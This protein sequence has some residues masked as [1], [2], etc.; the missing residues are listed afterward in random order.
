[1]TETF[2]KEAIKEAKKAY[3]E[4][5]IPIGCVIVSNGE[6]IGRG[7]NRV[8]QNQNPL[9]H[10]EL[11]A[12]EEAVGKI[13]SWRLIDCDLYVTLEPCAMCAGA[14]VHSRIR[15]VYFGA[16]DKKRGCC[17]SIMTLPQTEEFNHYVE[18]EG[19]ILEKECLSLIQSFFQD[20]RRRKKERQN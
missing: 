10:A 8:E 3:K 2:M 7:H 17:S 5:E 13:G 18:I 20:L 12:I 15:Q 6:I 19:G 9:H 16:Y 4:D 11:L 1:M 14:L